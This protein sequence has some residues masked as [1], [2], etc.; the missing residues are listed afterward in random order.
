MVVGDTVSQRDGCAT[1]W[2][3]LDSLVDPAVDHDPR[4]LGEMVA[5]RED[6]VT[7]PL[8]LACSG[9]KEGEST[10]NLFFAFSFWPNLRLSWM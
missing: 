1:P 2:Q 4:I 5:L 7:D 3:H 6:G 10:L 8:V 9:V